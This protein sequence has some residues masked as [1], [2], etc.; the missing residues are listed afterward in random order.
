MDLLAFRDRQKCP[1][2]ADAGAL[3]DRSV[4]EMGLSGGDQT[5]FWVSVGFICLQP[6]FWNFFPLAFLAMLAKGTTGTFTWRPG[7]A[8]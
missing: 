3:L 5:F 1:M 8:E 4:L 2:G 7:G 6:H